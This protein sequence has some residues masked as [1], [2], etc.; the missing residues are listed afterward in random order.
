MRTMGRV[1]A[2]ALVATAGWLAAPGQA[3]AQWQGPYTTDGLV[4]CNSYDDR[5]QVCPIDNRSGQV[6]VWRQISQTPCIEGQTYRV[7]RN[8]IEVRRGCR[9]IFAVDTGNWGGGGWGEQGNYQTVRCESRDGRRRTCA[10]DTSNGVRLE[11]EFSSSPCIRGRSW[12]FDRNGVWVDRGCRG[13]FASFG[14]WGGSGGWQGGNRPPGG[15]WGGSGG[16]GGG[17]GNYT[18]R[19]DC[20]SL[21]GGAR[22]VCYMP[23][24][25]NATLF[26]QLQGNRCVRGR[27]WGIERNDAIWVDE[28]CNGRF[29]AP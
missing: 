23:N 8:S 26:Q 20:Y 21:R 10:M 29:V 3:Q 9:A 25:R 28:G 4:E 7:N 16:S 6:R 17:I 24:A 5:P 12:G 22:N 1:L 11:R 15:G 18:Q 13:E 2:G 14:G 27:T 19:V